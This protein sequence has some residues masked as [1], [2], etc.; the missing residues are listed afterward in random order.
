LESGK[1]WHAP[2]RDMARLQEQRLIK[3][4]VP[5]ELILELLFRE[6]FIRRVP[7]PF[8]FL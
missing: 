8:K 7:K 5:P 2:I 4:D 6:N 1:I 3:L